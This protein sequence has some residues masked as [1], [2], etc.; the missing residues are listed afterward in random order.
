MGHIMEKLG[1]LF[2][3]GLLAAAMAMPSRSADNGRHSVRADRSGD[4]GNG[5]LLPRAEA[6]KRSSASAGAS[7]PGSRL[8]GSGLRIETARDRTRL[9]AN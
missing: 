7:T 6:L 9:H 8:L 2:I 5:L 4:A 1:T 3:C